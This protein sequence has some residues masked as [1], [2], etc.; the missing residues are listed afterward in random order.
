MEYLLIIFA[1]VASM[2]LPFVGNAADLGAL[3]IGY[4]E[5][6]VQ[7]NSDETREGMPASTNMHLKS[8]DRIWV[9]DVGKA[10]IQSRSG[11]FIRLNKNTSADVLRVEEHS[12]QFNINSG[13]AYI[14]FNGA[15]NLVQIDTPLSS[16]R[17]NK[18]SRVNI[19]VVS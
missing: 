1:A 11:T 12:G 13:V 15:D 19:E 8:G 18:R 6:D 7:I 3:R 17:I 10:E 2:A 9:P 4:I 16:I 5:G 14:N